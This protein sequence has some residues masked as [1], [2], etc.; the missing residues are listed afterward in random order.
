MTKLITSVDEFKTRHATIKKNIAETYRIGNRLL[1][2]LEKQVII[3]YHLRGES[4]K[5]T[6]DFPD[7]AEKAKKFL[8][9]ELYTDLAVKQSTDGA[10]KHYVPLDSS[11]PHFQQLLA[12]QQDIQKLI[13]NEL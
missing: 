2:F 13:L 10:N 1:D 5:L 6:A 12:K 4:E 9:Y 3:D 8:G 7:L 11:D